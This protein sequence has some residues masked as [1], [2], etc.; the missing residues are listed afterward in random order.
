MGSVLMFAMQLDMTITLGNVIQA[1][2]SVAGIFA[3]YVALRE[4]LVRIETQLEPLWRRYMADK[5]K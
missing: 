5:E 4:R 3:A 1:G 2:V